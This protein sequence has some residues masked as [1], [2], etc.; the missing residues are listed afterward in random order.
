MPLQRPRSS[1]CLRVRACSSCWTSCR[2]S[3]RR[4]RLTPCIGAVQ[5][6]YAAAGTCDDADR[7]TTSPGGGR[8]GGHAQ[9]RLTTRI[10]LGAVSHVLLILSWAALWM[11]SAAPPCLRPGTDGSGPAR[12]HRCVP[13]RSLILGDVTGPP[14]LVRNSFT[15]PFI[16]S[17]TQCWWPRRLPTSCMWLLDTPHAFMLTSVAV[18]WVFQAPGRFII[19][20]SCQDRYRGHGRLRA[21]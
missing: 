12:A 7:R 1:W 3:S 17:P 4:S 16:L 19:A 8:H 6:I 9:A 2:P 10:K 13:S 5:A 18:A 20:G 21:G 14:L 11:L 15:R